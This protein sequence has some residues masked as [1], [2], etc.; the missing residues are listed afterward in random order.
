MHLPDE[1]ELLREIVQQQTRVGVIEELVP[2][3][4]QSKSQVVHGGYEVSRIAARRHRG[5]ARFIPSRMPSFLS[6][7]I[8]SLLQSL[9]RCNAI[10]QTAHLSTLMHPDGDVGGT[11]GVEV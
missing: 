6:I 7:P 11:L 5:G 4:R 3:V 8:E 1:G 9:P 2:H 10:A